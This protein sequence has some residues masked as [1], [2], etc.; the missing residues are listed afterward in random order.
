MDKEKPK[1]EIST[2]EIEGWGYMPPDF[3]GEISWGEITR[4]IFRELLMLLAIAIGVVGAG[5]L[6][7][8]TM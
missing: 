2:I 1:F 4:L 5:I 7:A 6:C 3:K 8:L